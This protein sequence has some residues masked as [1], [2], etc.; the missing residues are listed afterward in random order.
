MEQ[1][2]YKI[3]IIKYHRKNHRKKQ[4]SEKQQATRQLAWLKA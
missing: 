3:H 4:L 1:L 2:N